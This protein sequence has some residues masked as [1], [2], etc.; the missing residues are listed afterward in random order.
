M[1]KKITVIGGGTGSYVV[2]QG[3]KK[4]PIDLGVIVSMTDSGGSTGRLR[5]QL[6]VLP[7]GDLRQCLIALSEASNLWRRLFLYRFEKGD[8]AGHNFGNIFLSALEKVSRNYREVVETASFVLKTKGEV[9]PVTFD[10][11][12]LCI[13]YKNGKVIKGEGNI[14]KNFN[15]KSRIKRA[16]LE[17]EAKANIKAVQRIKRSDY[18]IIAPGD[19][20][21]SIIP[22]FLVKK[23]KDAFEKS[24]AKIIFILNLMTKSGQTTNYKASDFIKEIFHYSGR[25]PDYVVVNNGRI[26]HNILNWYKKNK[27]FPVV[28]DLN[29][30]NFS[31]SVIKKDVVD[32][33]KID[34]SKKEKFIDPRVR[35]ILRH[36][37]FKLAKVLGKIIL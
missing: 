37:S 21:T 5:D 8:L 27:E 13:E 19:L 1:N 34:F 18:I 15:E 4:Y 7:P 32:R 22:V 10:K 28:N 9:I 29:E 23:I 30:K 35:S 16:Y 17:P 11:V 36:D 33:K 26:P 14:D 24:K 12:D 31:S 20:Y 6:G 2:L 3:L 25:L